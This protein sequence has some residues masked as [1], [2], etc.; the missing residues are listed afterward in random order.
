MRVSESASWPWY[1][2]LEV[3]GHPL[4]EGRVELAQPLGQG[5]EAAA[6]SRTPRPGAHVDRE[7]HELAG[8]GQGHLLGDGVARLVLRLPGAGAEV[9]RDHDL[10]Q[11]EQ[12]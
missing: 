1:C 9:G 4:D 5:Q 12:R 3:A 7:G 10:G 6:R 8:Q 11:P 2:D